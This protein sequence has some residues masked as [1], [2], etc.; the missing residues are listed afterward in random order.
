MLLFFFFL[1]TV[2]SQH[3]RESCTTEKKDNQLRWRTQYVTVPKIFFRTRR[4]ITHFN[5]IRLK[6]INALFDRR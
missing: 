5:A 4:P 3:G 6:K 2:Y 1:S